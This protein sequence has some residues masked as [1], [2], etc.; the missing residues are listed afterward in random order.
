MVFS[1]V[2]TVSL[3]VLL[4]VSLVVL[5][6]LDDDSFVALAVVNSAVMGNNVVDFSVVVDSLVVV[7]SGVVDFS[8]VVDSFVVTSG[9]V[10]FPVVVDSIVVTSED[11]DFSVVVDSSAVA[12]GFVDF[13]V[14]VDFV[15]VSGVVDSFVAVDSVISPVPEVVTGVSVLP[16]VSNALETLGEVVVPVVLFADAD[17]DEFRPVSFAAEVALTGE[18]VKLVFGSGVTMDELTVDVALI[19]EAIVRLFVTFDEVE[20]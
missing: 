11:V 10:D 3:V 4:V 14:V 12:P 1:I 13:S 8:V 7:T 5:G 9:I 16:F 6:D 17:A 15:V 20:D 18:V 2:F 19:S